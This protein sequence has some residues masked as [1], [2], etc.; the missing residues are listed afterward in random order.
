MRCVWWLLTCVCAPTRAQP[1]ARA[2]S[3]LELYT[4]IQSGDTSILRVNDTLADSLD[5]VDIADRSRVM[6]GVLLWAQHAQG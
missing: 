2:R 1:S 4:E 3:F 6:H 5:E